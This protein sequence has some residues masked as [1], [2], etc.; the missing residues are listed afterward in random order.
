MFCISSCFR[1][2]P[3]NYDQKTLGYRFSEG[4][5]C[6]KIMHFYLKFQFC[7]GPIDNYKHLRFYLFYFIQLANDIKMKTKHKHEVC[8]AAGEHKSTKEHYHRK[9]QCSQLSRTR[10][11]II[12]KEKLHAANQKWYNYKKWQKLNIIFHE[13]CFQPRFESGFV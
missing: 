12:L 8:W 9:V 4:S 3:L 5:C 2:F 7:L 13:I 10:Q 11:R 1:P 6:Q